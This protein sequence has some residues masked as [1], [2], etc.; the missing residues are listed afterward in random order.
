M[1]KLLDH[2]GNPLRPAPPRLDGRVL[3][4]RYDSARTTDENSRH[5]ANA[6]SLQRPR[7]ELARGPPHPPQPGPVRGGEQRLRR[8]GIVETLA[9]D[10]IGTG[11]RLQSSRPATPTPTPASPRR[12]RS[13]RPRRPGREAPHDA[14]G[15]R[16][17]R[18]GV[19]ASSPRT[20]RSRRPVKLDL[21]S[22]RPT[23]SPRRT[24]TCR[25]RERRRDRARRL[26]QPG[27]VPR[28]Q[29]APRRPLH[30]GEFGA[31]DRVPAGWSPLV[32]APPP[33]PAPR[34]PR[35]H[36]RPAA[37]RQLRR[38]TL[39][40]LSAAEIAALFAAL[41]KSTLP[42]DTDGGDAAGH[43][44][45]RLAGDR[46]R[47]DDRLPDGYD[48]TQLKAEQP[49]TTYREFKHDAERDRPLPEHAPFNVAA[50]NSRDY[51]YSSGR[52][53]HQV[54]HR[55]I[56]VDRYHL[57]THVLDRLLAA[58]L[59]EARLADPG[60]SP[61]STPPPPAAPP[62]VLG[63]L[64]HVDPEKEANAQATR[65]A[66]GT[67]TL[68]PRVRRRRLRLA[69]GR[70]TSRP[71][72]G[73]LRRARHPLPG[74]RR[75]A[76]PPARRPRTTPRG[77]PADAPNQR[78]SPPRPPPPWPSPP[79][80]PSPPALLATAPVEIQAKGEGKRPTFDIVG[81][82][83]AV[84]NVEGVLHPVIVDLAGLKAPG[85]G[86]PRPP[87]PRHRPDRRPDRR[88]QDRRRG[89][90]PD[91]RHH[92]RERR[93]ARG[94]HPGQERLQVAGLDRRRHPPPRVPRGRQA[95][96]RSTAARS[97]ARW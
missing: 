74:R 43:P 77:G 58:W 85:P 62:V 79:P 56:G 41:L 88:R 8:A 26:R 47:D 84:M 66:N 16:R 73:V 21:R 23:R 60:P 11:P 49:T 15:P 52:L 18:R 83:G 70:P 55:S 57:E 54:Y 7:R 17:R 68:S 48:V 76:P 45:V 36:P 87:R 22:S 9:N 29:G 86:D 1:P 95:R 53:D 33:R 34:R 14:R 37:V 94:R 42:P 32:Q 91:R 38:Y 13:G 51:N 59:A 78:P 75:A 71:R 46:P 93:R 35:D 65:L 24:P 96:P 5:W 92:R 80:R 6:D 31:F 4:S 82:T 81:Y 12:S 3:R 30:F 40:T 90:P 69:R 67:T 10:T 97:P 27:L 64:P 39:A 63:R 28:P 2:R 25:R 61:A 89:R 19:R 44:A 20:P 72:S 50:G